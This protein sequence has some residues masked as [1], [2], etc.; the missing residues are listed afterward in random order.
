MSKIS[1]L[2]DHSA[3]TLRPVPDLPATNTER[4]LQLLRD[5]EWEEALALIDRHWLEVWYH[6]SPPQ[7]GALLADVPKKMFRSHAGAAYLYRL[8][9]PGDSWLESS[10]IPAESV[11]R[12]VQDA[13][14]RATRQAILASQLRLT[15]KTIA[16]MEVLADSRSSVDALEKPLIDTSAGLVPFLH[17]QAGITALLAGSSVLAHAW[18]SRGESCENDLRFGFTKRDA[19]LK[20]ALLHAFYGDPEDA[21]R[22]LDRA[23]EMPRTESWAEPWID[24]T[25]MIAAAMIS[26][27]RNVPV[28]DADAH[29]LADTPLNSF[30]EM[31]PFALWARVALALGAGDIDTAYR[32]VASAE[33][34]TLLGTEGDGVAAGAIPVA[35][36]ALLMVHG[37]LAEARAELDR[38]PQHLLRVQLFR[39]R[40]EYL[41]GNLE[42]AVSLAVSIDEQAAGF[43]RS[44][45]ELAGVLAASYLAMGESD[46]ARD[47][48]CSALR[49]RDSL[50]DSVLRT[51]PGELVDHARAHW[52]SDPA[53]RAII[54]ESAVA[55][56][57]SVRNRAVELS[58]REQEILG[59]LASTH[60]LAAIADAM[61]I[62]HNTLK[63]HVRRIYQKLDVT[64][65]R[66]AVHQANLL[67][68]IPAA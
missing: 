17:L 53:L 3:R 55:P 40:L 59:Q 67:G 28:T 19:A 26:P 30:G 33:A 52:G 51:I 46:R 12:N 65:R 64:S 16:A 39:V 11:T 66:D 38:A 37:R 32:E 31:W 60:T 21:G 41:C 56:L 10:D 62:S 61:F 22:C 14:H 18:L 15:G 47:V 34:S 20:Q 58:Q 36:T 24:Q 8:T 42:Q 44:R 23:A 48:L 1:D 29:A 6:S 7:T 45:V 9:G 54:A 13:E 68:L 49:G 5:G 63:T 50:P 27:D 35:S 25:G 2:G 57:Y 4:A 43:M